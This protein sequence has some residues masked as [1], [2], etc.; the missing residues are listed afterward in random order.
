LAE[1]IRRYRAAYD[2]APEQ[3]GAPERGTVS[4]MAHTFVGSSDA[5]VARQVSAP[6][7]GYLRSYVAQTAASRD[8]TGQAV[9]LG[10]ARL[11]QLTE[12]AVRRYLAW[13]S[14]LGAPQTCAS[15]LA[16]LR[17]LGCDEVACFID[18]GLAGPDVLASLRR[19]ASVRKEMA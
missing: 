18:F 12:F 3:A 1:K 11:D 16:D 4:L 9:P 2:A 14:L 5:E 7:R 15:R 10:G 13:G 19:L 17:D 6:L 8:G